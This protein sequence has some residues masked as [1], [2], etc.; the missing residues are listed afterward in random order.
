MG[1]DHI[2]GWV[3][4]T[5]WTQNQIVYVI[6]EVPIDEEGERGRERERERERE[7]DGE[8]ERE[9][10]RERERGRERKRDGGRDGDDVVD[11]PT[12]RTSSSGNDNNNNNN[13]NNNISQNNCNKNSDNNHSHSYDNDNSHPTAS[14]LLQS[15]WGSGRIGGRARIVKWARCGGKGGKLSWHGDR[16][17]VLTFNFYSI[18]LTSLF[19]LLSLSLSPSVSLSLYLSLSFSFLIYIN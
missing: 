10:E 17:S 7:G 3:L 9:V 12:R 6:P 13:N 4:G 19:F 16:Y 14:P 8:I 5:V 15:L 11:S 2:R 18:P 1:E